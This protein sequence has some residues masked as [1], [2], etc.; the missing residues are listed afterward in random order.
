MS[1]RVHWK[2]RLLTGANAAIVSVFV[3]A[4][5]VVAVDLAGR[6]RLRWDVSADGLS[7]LRPETE[8]VIEAVGR[9]D[10]AVKITAFSA[11][12]KGD[13]AWVKDRAVRDLLR[14]IALRTDAIEIQFVDF[15]ADRLTA[16]RLGV[17]RYGT[18][19]VEG[20]DDRVDISDR[21]LFRRNK[22]KGWDFVGEPVV[23][24]AVH[25]VLTSSRRVVYLL[26]G[27]GERTV[28][29]TGPRGLGAWIGLLENHGFEVSPLDLLRDAEGA[30]PAIPEDTHAVLIV[31]ATAPL[32][33][34]EEEALVEYLGRGGRLGV[35]IDPGGSFPRALDLFGVRTQAGVVFDTVA[36]F[37]HEDRPV[38]RYGAHPVTEGLVE[39]N[40]TTMVAHAA[41]VDVAAAEG[42]VVTPLL[43]TSRRGWI[44]RGTERPA[45]YVEGED[46]PGPAS[47]VVALEATP[48]HP[49]VNAG[50]VTRAVVSGDTD[51]LTEELIGDG[52][53]NSTFAV[54]VVRWLTGDD[55]GL[56]RVGRPPG[57]RRLALSVGQ[58]R[59]VQWVVLAGLP[60]LAVLAGAVVWWGR[61]GR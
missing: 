19:V 40:V 60:L 6:Y 37:P 20:P 36:V 9:A 28:D 29:A 25:Q 35:F 12:Q 22:E 10:K 50:R 4:I 54:N 21:D 52:P 51:L 59:L 15:D 24:R 56:W 26:Q 7:T 47:V 18:V 41:P 33:P 34:V 16:E 53:G 3:V 1:E 39:G 48:P 32:A 27:H 5:V 38:L 46:G 13:E 49:K 57:V 17:S 55:D 14:E 61:R 44:E 43:A 45:V 11:Q 2:R 8:A 23:A 30:A 31:G 58:L 42:M